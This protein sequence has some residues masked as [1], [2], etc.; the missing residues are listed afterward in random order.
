MAT[1][2]LGLSRA[3]RA[4]LTYGQRLAWQLLESFDKNGI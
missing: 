4:V 3:G 2:V 1:L